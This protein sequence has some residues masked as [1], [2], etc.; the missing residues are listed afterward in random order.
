MKVGVLP[1]LYNP[2]KEGRSVWTK[3]LIQRDSEFFG[4]LEKKCYSN[5]A[6]G[7]LSK[8]IPAVNADASTCGRT[9]FTF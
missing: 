6:M 9:G 7:I 5:V 2:Q 8:E 3:I 1:F 4:K